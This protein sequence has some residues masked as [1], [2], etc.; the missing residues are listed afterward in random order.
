MVENKGATAVTYNL[1]VQN[2][3]ALAGASFSFPNG[4]SFTINAGATT[5]VP[6]TFTATGSALKHAREASAPQQLPAGFSR[7]WLTEAGGYA[8]FTPTDGSPKLRVALYAAPKPVSAM[9][10]GPPTNEVDG[11]RGTGT[12][13]LNLSGAAVNTGPNLGGGFDILSLVKPFELQFARQPTSPPPPPDPNVIRFV[14]VTSD[15]TVNTNKANTVI[16]FG[17]EGFADAATPDSSSSD[18]EIFIDVNSDGMFD[19]AIFLSSLANG[20]APSNAYFPVLVNLNTG[21]ASIPGFRTNLLNPAAADTNSFNNSAVLMSMPAAALG[22][23]AHGLP[24]LASP[25]GPTAFKYVVVTFDRHGNQVDQSPLLTYDLAHAGFDLEGGNFEPFYYADVPS[26]IQVKF[27]HKN[28]MSNGTRGIW[29]VHMHN[30]DG[31]RSDAIPFRNA[32]PF[33]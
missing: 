16:T 23:P 9:R 26:S 7:Q 13:D 12:F 5:I 30:G 18:K 8:V 10:S 19:F 27:D 2:D 3:P 21:A 15:Y 4:T 11:T 31:Q 33:P 28:F 20:T 29:L 1:S 14:G 25:G 6:V 32:V 22:D 24:A 17:I